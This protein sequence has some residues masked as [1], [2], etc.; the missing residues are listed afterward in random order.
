MGDDVEQQAARIAHDDPRPTVC[1]LGC[2]ERRQS[3]DF[4][5]Y[6]VCLDVQVETGPSFAYVLKANPG[7]RRRMAQA[8]EL[9]VLLD[10]SSFCKQGR[11]PEV[12]RGSERVGRRVAR[13]STLTANCP[14]EGNE[15]TACTITRA[16]AVFT[17]P[18]VMAAA[19]TG[20][21]SSR[22]ASFR[23]ERDSRRVRRVA[24]ATYPPASAA[25]PQDRHA[26]LAQVVEAGVEPLR[27]RR[28]RVPGHSAQLAGHGSISAPT[29]D[30]TG[31]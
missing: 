7:H 18:P 13:C 1:D 10:L 9:G 11:R 2:P 8:G 4:G 20:I 28:D 24:L 19:R 27:E 22:L 29:T 17:P 16:W 23:S 12:T 26:H 31:V 3:L 30:K 21:A 14:V 5:W 25:L 6:V 15:S